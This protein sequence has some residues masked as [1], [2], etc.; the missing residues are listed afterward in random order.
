MQSGKKMGKAKGV[1]T[2]YRWIANAGVGA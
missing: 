2:G 1:S